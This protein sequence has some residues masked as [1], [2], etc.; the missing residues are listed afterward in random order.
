[1]IKDKFEHFDRYIL[2]Q[3]FEIIHNLIN[4][5]ETNK[6]LE[7][8]IRCIELVYDTKDIKEVNFEIHKDFIDLHY[9]IEGRES[10]IVEDI[11]NLEPATEYFKDNDYQLYSGPIRESILLNKGEFIVLFPNE[12]HITGV[13]VEVGI[14]NKVKKCVYKIP[15]KE[16]VTANMV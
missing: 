7:K 2:N 10:I 15:I 12:A 5:N 1:M 3:Y 14:P 6:V 4:K 11:K 9:I 8:E 13:N 16:I